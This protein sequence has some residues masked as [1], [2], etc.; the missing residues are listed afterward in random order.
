[1]SGIFPTMPVFSS[2]E[3]D[4]RPV[5]AWV[6]PT[7]LPERDYARTCKALPPGIPDHIEV[8]VT[9]TEEGVERSTSVIYGSRVY[10]IHYAVHPRGRPSSWPE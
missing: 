8:S 3:K 9:L 4:A 10:L 7:L 6:K 1:M 2:A 5:C